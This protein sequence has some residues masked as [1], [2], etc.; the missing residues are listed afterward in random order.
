MVGQIG[1][2]LCLFLMFFG[3]VGIVFCS[4]F[5]YVGPWF[6]WLVD[7]VALL[8]CWLVWVGFGKLLC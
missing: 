7:L 8:V 3:L 4:F 6:G 1:I 2:F 5:K